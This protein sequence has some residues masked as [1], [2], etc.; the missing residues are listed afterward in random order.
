MQRK[1]REL[2]D[3]SDNRKKNQ[4]HGIVPPP[5]EKKEVNCAASPSEQ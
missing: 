4:E 5:M 1:Q 2:S 3:V